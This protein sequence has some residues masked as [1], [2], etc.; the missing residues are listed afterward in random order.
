MGHGVSL[1]QKYDIQQNGIKVLVL[2]MLS[3]RR[4]GDRLTNDD[5]LVHRRIV[6]RTNTHSYTR[7]RLSNHTTHVYQVEDRKAIKARNLIGRVVGTFHSPRGTLPPHS[8]P[9]RISQMPSDLQLLLYNSIDV[10]FV[11]VAAV[12]RIGWGES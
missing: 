10:V 9:N 2:E 3:G 11:V 6:T 5:G 7:K 1:G 8:F 12:C 4:G